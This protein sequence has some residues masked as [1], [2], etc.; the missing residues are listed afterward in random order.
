MNGVV[1]GWRLAGTTTFR[2]GQPIQVYTPS[3]GVGG[4]GS[5]WYNIGQ[6]RN[7]RPLTVPGQQLGS[8]TNGHAA[9]IGA[10]NQ[11]YYV[12]PSA[13]YLPTG[14]TLGT[15]PSTYGNW[16]GPGFSQWDMALMKE[17]PLGGES[18]RIQI[19]FE[20]QNVFNHMNAGMPVTGVTNSSFG[21]ITGQ[22]GNPRQAMVA[23]KLYF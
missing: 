18:R 3:G 10:A 2:T 13:Y 1:G 19:R 16:V 12:N 4:L 5:G 11:Q 7:Q 6:G 21:L 15:V 20:A 14:F 22:S 9:L 23:A 17:F 8:T